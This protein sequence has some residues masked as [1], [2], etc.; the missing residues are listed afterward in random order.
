MLLMGK[1]STVVHAYNTPKNWVW[2]RMLMHNKEQ[3]PAIMRAPAVLLPVVLN[4]LYRH[5]ASVPSAQLHP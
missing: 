4:S 5:D 3:D 2:S 1:P